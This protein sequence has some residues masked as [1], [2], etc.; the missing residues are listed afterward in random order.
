MQRIAGRPANEG[1]AVIENGDRATLEVEHMGPLLEGED[2][3]TT[4][5]EDARHCIRLYTELISF[6]Q[7][8]LSRAER[9]LDGLSAEA[10]KELAATDVPVLEAQ[11]ARYESRLEFWYRRAW[12]LEGIDLDRDQLEV[13]YRGRSLELTR[14]EY[15]L[16]ACLM[17]HPYQY[18]SARRLVHMA[19]GEQLAD[20]QLRVYVVRLRRKLQDLELPARLVNRPRKGYSLVFD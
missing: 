4:H 6:K 19:W 15:Q 11:L 16:L 1:R 3:N 10:K 18:L 12:E 13:H 5:A 2:P 8:L 9:A 14:R 7:E 17:R 20:E